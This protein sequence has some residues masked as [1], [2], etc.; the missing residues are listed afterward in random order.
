MPVIRLTRPKKKSGDSGE[1][2]SGGGRMLSRMAWVLLSLAFLAAMLLDAFFSD[3]GLLRVR[4]LEQEYHQRVEE[5][6]VKTQ[7]NADLK[8]E[9]Q[10]LRDD[11]KAVEGVAREELGMIK[12]GEDVYLFSRE[13]EVILP[14][15]EKV[16][17]KPKNKE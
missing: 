5:E 10:A 12:P 17:K 14:K 11:P 7:E 3:K 16:E 4:Q 8:E 2:A 15:E 1:A 9:I 13:P 6:K